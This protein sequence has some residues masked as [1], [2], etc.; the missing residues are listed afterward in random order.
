MFSRF[1]L[2]IGLHAIAVVAT[3]SQCLWQDQGKLSPSL[4]G[5]NNFCTPVKHAVN[6]TH[7]QYF[8]RRRAEGMGANT[9]VLV[10]DYGYLAPQTLEFA[11][12]CSHGYAPD[13]D[14]HFWGVCTEAADL[15]KDRNQTFSCRYLGRRDDCEWPVKLDKS[16]DRISIWSKRR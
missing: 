3:H 11:S 2:A 8:C 5:Y 15:G 13:C 9:T 16:P 10:A 1:F 4:Y 7:S 6:T 14:V 12:P